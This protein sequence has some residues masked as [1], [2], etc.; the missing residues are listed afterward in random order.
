[1]CVLPIIDSFAGQHCVL[2]PA[3]TEMSLFAG[4]RRAGIAEHTFNDQGVT[5]VITGLPTRWDWQSQHSL[6]K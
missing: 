6:Q 4:S 5:T 3:F 2:Y 1:M